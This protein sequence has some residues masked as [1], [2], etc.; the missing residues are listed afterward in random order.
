MCG[1]RPAEDKNN[2]RVS[3]RNGL[4]RSMVRLN[5]GLDLYA[6]MNNSDWKL[7]DVE[8]DAGCEFLAL[9]EVVKE[10]TTLVQTEN[11][12]TGALAYPLA[13]HTMAKLRGEQFQVVDWKAVTASSKLP[14]LVKEVASFSAVGKVARE[15]VILEGERRFCGNLT[16]EHTGESVVLMTRDKLAQMLDLRTVGCSHFKDRDDLRHECKALLKGDYVAYAL[17]AHQFNEDKKLAAA[18]KEAAGA[19]AAS[20]AVAKALVG[21][22]K[23][24][25]T[26]VGAAA[27]DTAV[28]AAVPAATTSA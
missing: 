11:H 22:V 14:L 12:F 16:E 20:K 28:P 2:T 18:A 24:K 27:S 21:G 6:T 7:S 17:R 1:A 10:A 3:A 25:A 13:E 5:R 8:W 15:R 23:R 19:A 4:V 9:F 26:V